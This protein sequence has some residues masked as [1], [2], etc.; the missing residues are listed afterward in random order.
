MAC[1]FN[2]N[3][4]G[5]PEASGRRPILC[6]ASLADPSR[7]FLDA[8]IVPPP[9]AK[10]DPDIVLSPNSQEFQRMLQATFMGGASEPLKE[11]SI[12]LLLHPDEIDPVGFG[13]NEVLRAYGDTKNLNVVAAL[14]DEVLGVLWFSA[15]EGPLKLYR[16]LNAMLASSCVELKEQAG[17][18][19]FTHGDPYETPATFTPRA[20]MA[21]LMKALIDKRRLDIR[22]YAR[23]AFKSGR[24]ARMGLGEFYMA[25]YDRTALGALDHTDWNGLS[26]YGSFDAAQQKGLDEGARIPIGLLS[27]SQM[28]IVRRVAYAGEIQSETQMGDGTTR[29]SNR[30]IEPTET[31]AAGLPLG[32]VVTATTKSIPTIVAYGKSA[33][34]E[35]R[36]LRDLNPWTL[37][38]IEDEVIGD[39]RKMQAY[40]VAGLVGYAPGADKL[41]AL[42]VELMP[43]VWKEMALT[44][45]AYDAAATPV[46][47][48]QLP[49]PWAKQIRDAMEQNKARKATQPGKAIPPP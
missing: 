4:V 5:E 1:L 23:F 7:K 28:S 10:D 44:V 41:V 43:N 49:D 27:A 2:A 48:D 20:P 14:P 31:F 35:V 38:V 45:P 12:Q 34:G 22:D 36:P 30:V 16:G 21:V 19:V 3:L 40:S 39:P 8:M 13:A 24:V 46:R 9:A 42:R 47:W 17:W 33:N 25:F 32:G 37:A 11:K 29:R 6:Q 18:A 15:Q 26:L